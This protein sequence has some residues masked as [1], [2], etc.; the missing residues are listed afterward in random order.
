MIGLIASFFV[1]RVVMQVA[2]TPRD[3]PAESLVAAATD[4]SLGETITSKHVR[5]VPWPKDAIPA[6]AVRTVAEAEGRVVRSSIVTGE[7]LI[8]GK[9]APQL[10]GRG[11]IMPILIP[12]GLRGITIKVDDAIRES[13]FVMPNSRVDVLVSMTRRNSQERIAKLILQDVLVLAAG[14]AVEIRDNKPVTVTTVTLAL[15]PDQSERLALAQTEGRLTLA[16]RNVRDSRLVETRGI[17]PESLI[18]PGVA[19]S[20]A[21]IENKV[22]AKH[23]ARPSG[24]KVPASALLAPPRMEVHTVSVVRGGKVTEQSFVRDE[25]RAWR[26]AKK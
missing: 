4:L 12:E 6:G 16:T 14:Q 17:T 10:A 21:P 25:S 9:L 18:A 19:P 23:P 2:R 1:Y 8:E 3:A 26:E 15:S 11:G 13:G 7:P 5:L 20:P 22:V 24:S